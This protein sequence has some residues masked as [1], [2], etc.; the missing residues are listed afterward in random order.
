LFSHQARKTV[1]Y[2]TIQI[3]AFLAAGLV[4]AAVL[5]RPMSEAMAA[6]RQK[7]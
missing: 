6:G 7:S 5:K 4:A 1:A 2:V 3:V